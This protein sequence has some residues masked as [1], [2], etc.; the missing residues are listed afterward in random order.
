MAI[1]KVAAYEKPIPPTAVLRTW[2]TWDLVG[3]TE[4]RVLGNA[5]PFEKT[6]SAEIVVAIEK[7]REQGGAGQPATAPE[8]KPEAKEEPKP[9]SKPVPR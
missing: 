3:E 8:S 1:V 7:I 2:M 4:G 9:E 5:D 6:P